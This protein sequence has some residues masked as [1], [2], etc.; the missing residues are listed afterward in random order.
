MLA[1]IPACA[2]GDLGCQQVHD[3][4]ILIGCPYRTVK[5]KK[6]RSRALFSTE[7]K[8]TVKEPGHKPLEADGDFAQLA[9]KISDN[10]ID[11]AAA[12]QGLSNCDVLPP[13]RPVRKQV[14]NGYCEIMVWVHQ[15]RRWSDNPVPV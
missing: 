4:P 6:T 14:S 7:A 2:C 3:W 8:R 1:R 11:H 9:V 5:A 10:P 13:F 12:H 15:S